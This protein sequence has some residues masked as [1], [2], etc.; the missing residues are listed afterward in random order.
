M[1]QT[2]LTLPLS[3]MQAAQ[4]VGLCATYRAYAWRTLPPSPERNQT[5]KALQSVQGRVSQA[6]TSGLETVWLLAS[7]E[8]KQ[9][10][11]QVVCL[12]MQSYGAEPSSEERNQALGEL[13]GLR[14]LIERTCRQTQAL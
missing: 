10:L 9:I 4:L 6:L 7:E 8:E 13:A 3:T 1:T 11:R 12:L 5:M 2:A 14:L